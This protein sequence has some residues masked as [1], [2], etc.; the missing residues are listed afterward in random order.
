MTSTSDTNATAEQSR[1]A[2][3][4]S[5]LG[6]RATALRDKAEAA[7]KSREENGSQ[8]NP[9]I[10]LVFVGLAVLGAG[11]VLGLGFRG[12]RAG[13]RSVKARRA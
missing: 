13:V 3:L 8:V 11:K 10:A 2:S 12:A 5:S 9:A 6:E 7:K 4:K 1:I